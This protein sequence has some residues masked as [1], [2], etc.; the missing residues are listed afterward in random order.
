MTKH[1]AVIASGE[2]E[3]RALPRL[4]AH[5]TDCGIEVSV[6]IPRGNRDLDVE[7]AYKLIQSAR[8]SFPP[9]DKFVILIDLDGKDPDRE[10]APF[11][12]NLPGRLGDWLNS[13]IQYAYAQWHLE[14][15]YFA[16]ADGLRA[17]LGGQA[18]G[19]VD[20]SQPDEIQNPKLHLKHLLGD[21]FYSARVSEQIA[22]ALDARII[23]QRS[24]SFHRLLNAVENGASSA[25]SASARFA[26]PPPPQSAATR[27]R[28]PSAQALLGLRPYAGRESARDG[29]IAPASRTA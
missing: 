19:S 17:F 26:T 22:E 20:T 9:P 29:G 23:A 10:L 11:R 5:L 12:E 27:S 3:R 6:S 21:C 2:T 8:Y 24:P 7:R 1:V 18:L 28:R 15:W 4:L 13:R 16:D 25:A 14:A